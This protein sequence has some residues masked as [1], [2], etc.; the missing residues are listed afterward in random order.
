MYQKQVLET[1][2]FLRRSDCVRCV[3][4]ASGSRGGSG[5]MELSTCVRSAL[6]RENK[7]FGALRKQ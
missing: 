3:D 6:R 5:V 2:I 1:L 7:S 4:I